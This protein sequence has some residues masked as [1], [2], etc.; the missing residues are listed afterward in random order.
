MKELDHFYGIVITLDYIHRMDL[1]LARCG[2][3]VSPHVDTSSHRMQEPASAVEDNQ[4]KKPSST[5]EESQPS[6]AVEESKVEELSPAGEE[7]QLE[8]V[9]P[10]GE[11]SQLEE[12][13]HAGEDIQLQ[14]HASAV[15]ESWLEEFAENNRCAFQTVNGED[16][17]Q[18]PG[19]SGNTNEVNRTSM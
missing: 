13:A 8:E 6:S 19:F 4:L 2:S 14:D 3:A 9:A 15:E 12:V 16:M 7:S 5:V 10:A 1:E 11:E 18:T 17:T